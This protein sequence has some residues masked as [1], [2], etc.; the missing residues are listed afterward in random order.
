MKGT[1]V[2]ITTGMM[3]VFISVFFM[4]FIIDRVFISSANCTFDIVSEKN[5]C[6]ITDTSFALTGMLLIGM[7]SLISI[8]VAYV[9]IS[10]VTSKR[11]ICFGSSA[12]RQ[13]VK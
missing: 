8:I 12:I 5:V 9:L 13:V 3:I 1:K 2:L 4:L 6:T 10:T 11:S 7:F